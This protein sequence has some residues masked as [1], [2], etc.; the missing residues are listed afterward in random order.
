MK[1]LELIKR[2]KE[3]N[4]PVYYNKTAIIDY[5]MPENRIVSA[6]SAELK[7][8]KQRRFHVVK[9]YKPTSKMI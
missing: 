3:Y 1:T 7:R 8:Y 2:W 5:G 6:K 4:L 9:N